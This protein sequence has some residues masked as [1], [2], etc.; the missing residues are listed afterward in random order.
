MRALGLAISKTRTPKESAEFIHSEQD[1]WR[2][3][4]AELDLKPQ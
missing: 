1:R 2:K 3:L 4:A